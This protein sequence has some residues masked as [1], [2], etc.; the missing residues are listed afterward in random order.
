MNYRIKQVRAN[1]FAV[2]I[3]DEYELA[4]TFCR[5]Q[6]FYESPNIEFRGQ[7]FDIWKFIDWYSRQRNGS[8]TYPTDWAGFNI[9]FDVL[10]ECTTGL[11]EIQSP[12]DKTLITICSQ[13]KKMKKEGPAYVIGVP[14]TE[15]PTFTH[16]VSHGLYY[17]NEEYREAANK[18]IEEIKTINKNTYTTFKRNLMKMGYTEDVIDD[19]I[20]AYLTT[21]WDHNNFGKD[22]KIGLK[23]KLHDAFIS[24]LQKYLP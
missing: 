2:I 3:K 6:E 15:S 4:M 20:H 9:P 14:D 22:V 18:I 7:H 16:E 21:N 13:L 24:K 10:E 23:K 8:F 1:V 17:T 5:V 11:K 19:E 12:Y